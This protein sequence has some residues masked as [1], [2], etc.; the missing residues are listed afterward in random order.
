[1]ENIHQ[2]VYCLTKKKTTIKY[3][4]SLKSHVKI[5]HERDLNSSSS[6]HGPDTIMCK[7]SLSYFSDTLKSKTIMDHFQ[8]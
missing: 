4:C 8:Q 7:Q 2:M 1:V 6:A 5:C 3:A